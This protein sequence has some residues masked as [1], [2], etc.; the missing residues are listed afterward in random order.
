MFNL[1][2]VALAA[3]TVCSTSLA[4]AQ[5]PSPVI[6]QLPGG[7]VK[8]AEP[9]AGSVLQSGIPAPPS[10]PPAEEVSPPPEPPMPPAAVNIPSTSNPADRDDSTSE[11]EVTELAPV[12][13][14]VPVGVSADG[15][16]L[17]AGHLLAVPPPLGLI[18]P[19]SGTAGSHIRYPY[20]SYRRPWY[21][22][23]PASNNVTIVW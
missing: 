13:G 2:S 8:P 1:R 20:Y 14:A 21:Y 6:P 9:P 3:I 16:E 7:E 4:V 12:V 11:H 22:P 19:E 18:A 15:H 10:A 5:G 17:N 23:G